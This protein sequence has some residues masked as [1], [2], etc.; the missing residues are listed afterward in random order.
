MSLAYIAVWEVMADKP[1]DLA[2]TVHGTTPHFLIEKI[3][4]TRIY[5]SKY[6]KESCFALTAETIVDKAAE[7]TYI[8]GQHS[9]QVPTEFLCLA[10][11]LLLLCPEPEIIKIYVENDEL[12][13]VSVFLPVCRALYF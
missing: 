3:I 4:R 8:G 10:L 5:D 12:K 11:K 2:A 7:L 13:Y 6:W 9:N 1:L